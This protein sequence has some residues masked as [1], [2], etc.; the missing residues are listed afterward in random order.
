MKPSAAVELFA[1]RSGRLLMALL[2][3]EERECHLRLAYEYFP[4][5]PP[6]EASFFKQ[7]QQIAAKGYAEVCDESLQ[8]LMG[9]NRPV[10]FEQLRA[11]APPSNGRLMTT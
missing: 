4:D 7:L 1:R 9:A 11:A 2:P 6:K 10:C 8:G 3:G 5:K